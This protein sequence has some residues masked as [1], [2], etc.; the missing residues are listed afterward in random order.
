MRSY[1]SPRAGTAIVRATP[2]R[3]LAAL[4]AAYAELGI[5][6]KLREPSR[7]QIGNENFSRMYR[8]AHT[9]LSDYVGCGVTSWGAAA[10]SYRITMSLVSQ[11]TA[12]PEGTRIDT[13]LFARAED[14]G[15][16]KGAIGCQSLGTLEAKVN[17]LAA[18]HL[19][20]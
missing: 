8:L 9:P 4:D 16:S 1:E 18:T 12:V 7:G 17:E 19:G 14:M 15:S 3:A 20:G 11:V 10:D 13:Q 6:V 2:E 5:E